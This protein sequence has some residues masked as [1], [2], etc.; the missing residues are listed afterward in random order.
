MFSILNRA[1]SWAIT[2]FGNKFCPKQRSR[3]IKALDNR[4][5]IKFV[6]LKI[7]LLV[8]VEV[9]SGPTKVKQIIHGTKQSD[10]QLNTHQPIYSYITIRN[11]EISL[12]ENSSI[13]DSTASKFSQRNRTLSFSSLVT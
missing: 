9:E 2:S 11:I 6:Q 5:Y 8:P 3:L 4:F 13:T 7:G 12:N 1:L 10:K